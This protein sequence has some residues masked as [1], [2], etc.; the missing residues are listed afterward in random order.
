MSS[1]IRQFVFEVTDWQGGEM[2]LRQAIDW[3]KRCVVVG[4]QYGTLT[5]MESR[6]MAKRWAA[7][8]HDIAKREGVPEGSL[9]Y[10]LSELAEA[11]LRNGS[12]K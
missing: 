6:Y 3:W 7:L 2:T 8:C 12:S 9:S 4:T 10:Y 1:P 11:E 5:P